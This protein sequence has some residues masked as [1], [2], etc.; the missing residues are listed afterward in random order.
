MA[1]VLAILLS[2]IA[3]DHYWT[4][5]LPAFLVVYVAARERRRGSAVRYA[6]W[7][8]AILTTGL[9]P[10]TLGGAGFNLARERSAYTVA[11][12]ILYVTL[13]AVGGRRSKPRV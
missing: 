6:F 13:V 4:M 8:A 1:T 2:P 9:S 3:W 12:L 11:A 5:M 10:M 7:S